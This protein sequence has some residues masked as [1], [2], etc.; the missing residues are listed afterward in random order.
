MRHA[1]YGCV[2]SRSLQFGQFI[3]QVSQTNWDIKELQCEHSSYV[4]TLVRELHDFNDRLS[5]IKEF[6]HVSLEIRSVIW[7]QLTV[8]IFR[9]LVYA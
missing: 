9:A 7:T 8:C 3:K 6:A 5:K 1:A 2:A 4:D